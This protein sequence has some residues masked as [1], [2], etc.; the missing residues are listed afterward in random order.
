[1]FW[2]NRCTQPDIEAMEQRQLFYYPG[3]ILPWRDEVLW[4][5]Q[6][7]DVGSVLLQLTARAISIHKALSQAYVLQG[8][9]LAA[10]QALCVKQVVGIILPWIWEIIDSDWSIWGYQITINSL[11]L[12]QLAWWPFYHKKICICTF[13]MNTTMAEFTNLSSVSNSI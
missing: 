4:Q 5:I 11:W 8:L 7:C 6:F 2:G 13:G 12:K 9:Q 1:M 3:H 10:T